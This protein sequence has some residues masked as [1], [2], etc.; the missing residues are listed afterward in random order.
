MKNQTLGVS[1]LNTVAHIFKALSEPTRLM[2]LQELQ[3]GE[4]SVNELALA[5]QNSQP[6]VSKHL[7]MLSQ[8]EITQRRQLGNTVYYFIEDPMVYQLCDLV[9]GNIQKRLKKQL[10]LFTHTPKLLRKKKVS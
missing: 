8:A 2:I 3:A 4:K 10:Q 7:K 9:C 6:N 5:T 1:A